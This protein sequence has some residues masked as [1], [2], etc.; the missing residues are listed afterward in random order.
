M[1]MLKA[2]MCFD[3]D[4]DQISI[5]GVE[6]TH[7]DIIMTSAERYIKGAF[8]ANESDLNQR[9]QRH[10]V[11]ALGIIKLHLQFP[12]VRVSDLTTQTPGMD[13]LH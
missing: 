6:L 9:T 1:G 10:I 11:N 2:R 3:T 13:S 12:N 4:R 7:S 5:Y 8:V